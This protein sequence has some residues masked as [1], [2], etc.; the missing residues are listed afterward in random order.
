M[1]KAAAESSPGSRIVTSQGNRSG[2]WFHWD[3]VA[4]L[5]IVGEHLG[6]RH[7][8]ARRAIVVSAE[9]S[10]PEWRGGYQSSD[11]VRSQGDRV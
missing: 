5:A 4:C 1:P 9:T 7:S 2:H 3:I 6:T 10:R 8:L 11:I